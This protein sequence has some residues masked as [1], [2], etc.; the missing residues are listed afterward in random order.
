MV[1]AD[2]L[3]RRAERQR[4]GHLHL[5][6][7]AVLQGLLV[8]GD[9]IAAPERGDQQIRLRGQRLGDVRSEVG[10]EQLGPRL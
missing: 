6:E 8:E 10:G 2:R 4:G 5:V 1:L 7:E 3:R 9:V